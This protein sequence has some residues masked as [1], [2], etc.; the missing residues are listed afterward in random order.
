MH[1]IKDIVQLFGATMVDATQFSQDLF[2]YE[3]RITEIL[4]RS[5]ENVTSSYKRLTIKELNQILFPVRT[6]II[7]I[8]FCNKRETIS[9]TLYRSYGLKI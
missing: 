7:N 8:L 1:F 3:K 4:D 2:F 6:F 5:E 9:P